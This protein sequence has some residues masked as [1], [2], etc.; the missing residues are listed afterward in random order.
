MLHEAD[1][2][3]LGRLPHVSRPVLQRGEEDTEAGHQ[4]V[5]GQA[6]GGHQVGSEPAEYL[7]L[8]KRVTLAQGRG[9]DVA[10]EHVPDRGLRHD[11]VHRLDCGLPH[12]GL[13]VSEGGEDRRQQV[14]DVGL[15]VGTH[16]QGQ[17]TCTSI[18]QKL[19]VR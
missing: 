18:H 8:D 19:Y 12:V 15:G 3:L 14:G 7:L 4:L 16:S 2:G 10:H 13:G 11:G 9:E 17:V 1:D 6:L 5:L